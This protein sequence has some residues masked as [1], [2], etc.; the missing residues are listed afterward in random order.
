MKKFIIIVLGIIGVV[1]LYLVLAVNA[2]RKE[3]H[4]LR[5]IEPDSISINE[6]LYRFDD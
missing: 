3:L 6:S 4:E 2:K 1:Y 5:K